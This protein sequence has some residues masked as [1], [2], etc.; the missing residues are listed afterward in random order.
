MNTL[1]VVRSMP[2]GKTGMG[3]GYIGER[4]GSFNDLLHLR[5][6]VVSRSD[7][8]DSRGDRNISRLIFRGLMPSIR[9]PLVEF[10]IYLVRR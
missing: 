10:L 6:A 2:E 8:D 9:V 4:V 3:S 1:D 7:M 5:K